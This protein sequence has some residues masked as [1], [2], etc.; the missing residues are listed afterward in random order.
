MA[1]W[2]IGGLALAAI[3]IGGY[4]V[5]KQRPL[6]AMTTAADGNSAIAGASLTCTDLTAFAGEWSMASAVEWAAFADH[7][8]Y[9]V[10]YRLTLTPRDGCN[11]TIGLV[12]TIRAS[13]SKGHTI[14]AEHRAT[15]PVIARV[16]E[17]ALVL[18]ARIDF[19]RDELRGKNYANTEGFKEHEEMELRLS[20]RPADGGGFIQ[21]IEGVTLRRD[22]QGGDVR[23][24]RLHVARG[25]GEPAIPPPSMEMP[26]WAACELEC[27]GASATS[28]CRSACSEPSALEVPRCTAPS[29]DFQLPTRL[30]RQRSEVTEGDAS[31]LTG[32]LRRA[33]E[34]T[35]GKMSSKTCTSTISALAGDWTIHGLDGPNSVSSL[36]LTPSSTDGVETMRGTLLRDGTEHDVAVQVSQSGAWRVM[37]ASMTRQGSV[38]EPFPRFLVVGG[39]QTSSRAFGVGITLASPEHKLRVTRRSPAP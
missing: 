12:Q 33:C 29:G 2:V 22:S 10:P 17:G 21:M 11:T 23:R 6:D 38:L 1:M 20:S 31:G 25:S 19:E 8:P 16:H 36:T 4:F 7:Y 15:V 13:E 30:R 34:Q 37:S 24:T 35:E 39:A 5:V 14:L 18:R 26:C 3:G 28:A 9:T 32:T 27:A